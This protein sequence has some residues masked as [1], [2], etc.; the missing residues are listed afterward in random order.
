MET[1]RLKK[2][3]NVLPIGPN[4]TTRAEPCDARREYWVID[5][6]SILASESRMT[7]MHP[8][9]ESARL[10]EEKDETSLVA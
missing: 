9:P 10:H 2:P 8:S 5:P 6:P 3:H 7:L 1:S 4:V